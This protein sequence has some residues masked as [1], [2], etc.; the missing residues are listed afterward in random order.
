MMNIKTRGLRLS[1]LQTVPCKVSTVLQGDTT[2]TYPLSLKRDREGG[3]VCGLSHPTNSRPMQSL[4]KKQTEDSLTKAISRRLFPEF[5]RPGNFS[6]ENL[7]QSR[8]RTRAHSLGQLM[9]F[10]HI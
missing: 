3:V 4:P 1:T 8:S 9:T 2:H 5:F 10:N 7:P 6:E